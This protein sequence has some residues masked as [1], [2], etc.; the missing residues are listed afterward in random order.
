M[1]KIKEK[2]SYSAG[3]C[4]LYLDDILEIVDAMRELDCEDDAK[5]EIVV[6][7]YELTETSEFQNMKQK[8]HNEIEISYKNSNPFSMIILTVRESYTLLSCSEVENSLALRGAFSIVEKIISTHIQKWKW[9][10]KVTIFN[11]IPGLLGIIFVIYGFLLDL[12]AFTYFGIANSLLVIV[13]FL[14]YVFTIPVRKSKVV[15]VEKD[16][17]DTFW[18]RN[19]DSLIKSFILFGLGVISTIAIQILIK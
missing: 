3:P 4:K 17:R 14:L 16:M 7:G 18:N 8:E 13:I 15:L 5:L 2:P 1:K 6:G 12:P 10:E 19:K 9:V 11:F